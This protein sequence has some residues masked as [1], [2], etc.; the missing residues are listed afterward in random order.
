[1]THRTLAFILSWLLLCPLAAAQSSFSD[2]E[3]ETAA[4]AIE[5]LRTDGIVEGYADGTYRPSAFINRAE[6]LA[7]L[8]RSEFGES[9]IDDLLS[10]IRITGFPDVASDSWYW[11]FVTYAHATGIISGYPDGFFRPDLRINIAEASKIAANVFNVPSV[12]IQCVRTPCEEAWWAPYVRALD[13]AGAL[14][15]DAW[16]SP[17][18]WL[19]RGEMATLTYVLRDYPRPLSCVRRGCSG[20]LCVD[21]GLI[22]DYVTTCEWRAIYECYNHAVCERQPN[23]ACG[24][25]M[26]PALSLCLEPY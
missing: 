4:Q 5:S 23:G 6:F 8:L 24:W 11:R 10:R 18:R 20:Q 19:T 1:M 16:T 2:L 22:D 12:A 13:T 3:G 15:A 14:P 21:E 25:T 9:E 17:A 26:T 7:I